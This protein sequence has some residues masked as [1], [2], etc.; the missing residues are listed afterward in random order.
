M[1]HKYDIYNSD[2]PFE[3]SALLAELN[4]IQG[5]Q[6]NIMP[7][8]SLITLVDNLGQQQVFTLIRNSGHSNVSSLLLEG[9][10]LL[11]EEDYLTITP[12]II[13][14]YPSALFRVNEFRLQQFVEQISR[15]ENEKDY[16]KLLDNFGIRRSDKKFW[17]NSDELHTWFYNHQ[18]LQSGLLDYNRLENR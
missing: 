18:P 1:N 4:R 6:A 8:L 3:H 11:P 17:Q 5:K 9:M 15:L 10:N 7:E 16:A 2:T 14:S 13:G 12:G